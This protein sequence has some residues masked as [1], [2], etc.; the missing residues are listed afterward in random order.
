MITPSDFF[1]VMTLIWLTSM[2]SPGYNISIT[3]GTWVTISVSHLVLELQ[4]ILSWKKYFD[5]SLKKWK[6]YFRSNH[7]WCSVKK[8]FLKIFFAIFTSKHLCWSFLFRKKGFQHRCFAVNIAKFLRVIISKNFCE[9]L[10]LVL[11]SFEQ[12]LEG[13]ANKALVMG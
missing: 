1:Y 7:Q 3:F 9:R 11:L 5:L 8:L 10:L 12:Y 13:K 4:E 2:S 6:A